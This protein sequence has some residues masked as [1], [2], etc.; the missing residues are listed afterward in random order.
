MNAS[1]STGIRV[2]TDFLLINAGTSH[3]AGVVAGLMVNSLGQL[4]YLSAEVDFESNSVYIYL[5]NGASQITVGSG[6]IPTSPTFRPFTGWYRIDLLI[7]TKDTNEVNVFAEL[8]PADTLDEATI[9][10]IG[11]FTVSGIPTYGR[12]GLITRNAQSQFSYLALET[13]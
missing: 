9:V 8:R 7:S 6:A 12:C 13:F 3:N 10:S 5:V 2:R 4:L 1:P 11:P